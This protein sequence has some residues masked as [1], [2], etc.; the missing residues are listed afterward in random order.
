MS[1]G[2][3]VAGVY[4]R[5]QDEALAFYVENSGFASTR[6]CATEIFDG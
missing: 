3:Q 6:T 5:D 4:V 1:S 2:I